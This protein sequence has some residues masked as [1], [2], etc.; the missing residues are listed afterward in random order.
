MLLGLAALLVFVLWL[1]KGDGVIRRG[2]GREMRLMPKGANYWASLISCAAGLAA[3][4]A[5]LA[6][7][8]S[9]AYYLIFAMIA[10][11][12]GLLVYYTVKLM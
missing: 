1:K 4:L 3:V 11:L 9:A 12:F 2:G 10:W 5:S 6:L 7:G 8:P